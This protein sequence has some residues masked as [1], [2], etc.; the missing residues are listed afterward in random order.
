MY[1]DIEARPRDK[2]KMRYYLEM[3]INEYP[4]LDPEILGQSKSRLET[5]D[6]TFEELIQQ[7]NQPS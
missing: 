6:L 5:I 1:Y 3:L 7:Q 4:N 2:E